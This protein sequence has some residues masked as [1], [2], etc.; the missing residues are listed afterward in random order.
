ME[1]EGTQDGGSVS[2]TTEHVSPLVILPGDRDGYKFEGWVN[3]A[4][5]ASTTLTLSLQFQGS[6]LYDSD[7]ITIAIPDPAVMPVFNDSVYF[8]GE[9]YFG[10]QFE[11]RINRLPFGVAGAGSAFQ[12]KAAVATD[13][14]LSV[15]EIGLR[16]KPAPR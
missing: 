14:N 9:F 2:F 8:G 4:E 10:I 15:H 5:I 16:L 13:E 6:R 7:D 3:Y 11:G 1:G 12:I